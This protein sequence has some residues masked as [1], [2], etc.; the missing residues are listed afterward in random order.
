MKPVE[1]ILSVLLLVSSILLGIAGLLLLGRIQL[2]PMTILLVVA[3]LYNLVLEWLQRHGVL[4][5]LTKWGLALGNLAWV[6]SS[7]GDLHGAETTLSQA[8]DLL[9]ELIEVG[10]AAELVPHNEAYYLGLRG[11]WQKCARRRRAQ[12]ASARERGADL[13]RAAAGCWLSTQGSRPPTSW[14]APGFV[15]RGGA[16]G[17]EHEVGGRCRCSGSHTEITE[18]HGG[19]TENRIPSSSPSVSPPWSSSPSV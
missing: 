11:E 5:A 2:L 17:A 16:R 14:R 6:L 15:H 19:I 9:N 18:W 10:H 13:D 1:L 4:E 8:Q 7:C 12:Q 3:L